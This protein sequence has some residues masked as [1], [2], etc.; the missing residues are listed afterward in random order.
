MAIEIFW[1]SGSPY[2]WR[3]LLA[4]E[5]KG[6]PY[7]SHVLSFDQGDLK[8]EE[9]RAI[10]PRAKVPALRAGSF[11]LS[12]SLAI[13]AYLERCNPERPLFGETPEQAGLIQRAISEYD[14]YVDPAAEGFIDPLYFGG[15]EQHREDLARHAATLHAELGQLEAALTAHPF[16]IDASVTAADLVWYPHVKSVERAASKPAAEPFAFGFVPLAEHYPAIDAWTRRI[17]GLPGYD[18]T[19]P[20]HWR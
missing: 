2:A 4:L 9:F 12:E 17:E 16:I 11:V 1:A 6:M 7:E 3:V 13:L 14:L 20:P 15:A 8:T 18:R 5:Y 19:Y 10:S